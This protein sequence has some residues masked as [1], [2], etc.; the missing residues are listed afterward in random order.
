M[1]DDEREIPQPPRAGRGFG[2][3]GGDPLSVGGDGLDLLGLGRDPTGPF[4]GQ[5]DAEDQ[6]EWASPGLCILTLIILYLE[7][8]AVGFSIQSKF[9]FG[10][11]AGVTSSRARTAPGIQYDPAR[12]GDECM[13]VGAQ[14]LKEARYI[15][16]LLLY[17]HRLPGP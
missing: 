16:I 3:S 9:I 8:G 2:R 6:V 13:G 4:V 14:A 5:Y 7:E 10:G 1:S 12:P 15:R 11:G 17:I